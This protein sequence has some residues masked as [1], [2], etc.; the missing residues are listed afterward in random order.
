M[1][2]TAVLFVHG[3]LGRPEQFKDLVPLV[4][5]EYA[6]RNL[7]LKGHGGTP[8]DFGR[9]SISE[10]KEEVHREA[11]ALCE[12]YDRVLM[13][14]HSLGTL[15]SME[16]AQRLPIAG[17]F[18]ANVPLKVRV[19]GRLFKMSFQVFFERVDESNEFIVG[20]RDS[21]GIAPDQN[22]FHYIK[23]IPRYLELFREMRHAR[24]RVQDVKTPAIAFISERD[25]MASPKAADI[26]RERTDMEVVMLPRSGHFYYEAGDKRLMQ[27]RFQEFLGC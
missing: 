11:V 6:V 24:R 10:W 18:L 23:W 20:A 1:G 3:I 7:T 26:L 9:Y 25:E 16:E 12:K 19:T 5:Q 4:P 21:Y 14:G 17:L 22:I 15:F 2:T 13:V 8:K 27:E